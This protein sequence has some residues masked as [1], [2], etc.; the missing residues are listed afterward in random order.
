MCLSGQDGTR[1]HGRCRHRPQSSVLATKPRSPGRRAVPCREEHRAHGANV[2]SR[3]PRAD[4][5]G[6]A[7]WPRSRISG[8][9]PR[10]C[11]LAR[12]GRRSTGKG[13]CFFF[14]KQMGKG[15]E[16]KKKETWHRR[17]Q[18]LVSK[19]S[20]MGFCSVGRWEIRRRWR[21]DEGGCAWREDTGQA[22]SCAACVIT[23]CPGGGAALA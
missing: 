11:H 20:P 5:R 22:R 17:V 16:E 10:A 8:R 7:P 19:H 18:Y 3:M 21:S 23:R 1:A 6:A 14:Q 2:S 9:R 12:P 13:D 15:E 4:W